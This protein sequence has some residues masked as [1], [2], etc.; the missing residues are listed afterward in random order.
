MVTKEEVAEIIRKETWVEVDSAHVYG[1]EDAADK[2][3]QAITGN[4]FICPKCKQP[5]LPSVFLPM[6]TACANTERNVV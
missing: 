6:C 4:R 2:I 5:G 1:I 3:M